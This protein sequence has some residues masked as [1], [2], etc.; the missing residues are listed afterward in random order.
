MPEPSRWTQQSERDTDWGTDPNLVNDRFGRLWSVD[1]AELEESGAVVQNDPPKHR[2]CCFVVLDVWRVAPV[3]PF[4]VAPLLQ[5]C[6]R[7]CRNGLTFGAPGV[8]KEHCSA[9][10]LHGAM[11]HR[12]LAML[13]FMMFD[14]NLAPSFRFADS[15]SRPVHPTSQCVVQT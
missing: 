8:Q 12:F 6:T 13:P 5:H 1:F 14:P 9:L 7:H 10:S 4:F 3:S 11:W 2:A 15:L